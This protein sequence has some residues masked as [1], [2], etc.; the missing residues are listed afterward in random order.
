MVVQS[1]L[2]TS[3]SADTLGRVLRGIRSLAI[4]CAVA[5][6][7]AASALA[8]WAGSDPP[9]NTKLGPLPSTCQ[10]APFG[11]ECVNADVYYLD[12]ARAQV[13]LPPYALPANFTS[14]TPPRQFFILV[15]LDRLQYGL[16]P[17]P[18]M[19]TALNHDAL[20]TGVWKGDDPH[21]TNTTGLNTW[22]P[23]AAGWFHNAP[24]AYEAAMWNDGLGSQNPRCTSTD[25]SRCWGHR[26]SILWKFPTGSVLAMG[27]ATGFDPRHRRAYGWLFVGGNPGVYKPVYTYTWQQAVEDGAGTNTY[28]PGPP[29]TAMCKVPAVLGEK[30]APAE[31]A[32]AKGH[33]TLGEVVKKHAYYVPGLVMAQHPAPGK[34][35]P[36]GTAVNLTISLGP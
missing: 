29:P 5:L 16:P 17:I 19:T 28:D 31:R 26:H 21:P 11:A 22:W 35:L 34:V 24:E 32:I 14:L 10:S 15:N 9:K 8:D 3:E 20:A 23:G 27:A 30:L 1:P 25:H 18:G 12:K 2:A 33:C 36:S 7:L 13:D 6:V 4:A